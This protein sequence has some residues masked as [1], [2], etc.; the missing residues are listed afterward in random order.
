MYNFIKNEIEEY[1]GETP[2]FVHWLTDE[3]RNVA[4]QE[5]KT[6]P[7]MSS[8]ADPF[9]LVEISYPDPDPDYFHQKIL[10]LKSEG[11]SSGKKRKIESSGISSNDM[12]R[13]T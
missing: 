3:E 11:S 6:I 13:R 12:K 7:L 2:K 8:I 10:R 9:M 4:K 5:I 1:K